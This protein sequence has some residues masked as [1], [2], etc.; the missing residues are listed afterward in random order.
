VGPSAKNERS[1]IV[2]VRIVIIFVIPKLIGDNE[3]WPRTGHIFGD[4]LSCA[5]IMPR[6][7][8]S[9]LFAQARTGTGEYDS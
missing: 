8:Y 1:V 7:T 2:K 9:E 3:R 4:S 5:E 6:E